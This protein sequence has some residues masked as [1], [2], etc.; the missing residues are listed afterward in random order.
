MAPRMLPLRLVL[1]AITASLALACSR[2]AAP[3]H[4][5][6]EQPAPSVDASYVTIEPNV[7]VSPAPEAEQAHAALDPNADVMAEILAIPPGR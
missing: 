7:S 6:A 3:A 1:P 2:S 5:A 4:V